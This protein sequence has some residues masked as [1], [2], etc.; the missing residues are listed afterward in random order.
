MFRFCT[1]LTRHRFV[2]LG[3]M[4]TAFVTLL[5]LFVLSLKPSD[6][7]QRTEHTSSS[8]WDKLLFQEDEGDDDGG[9]IG[10][11][12]NS[13]AY[14]Q[15]AKLEDLQPRQAFCPPLSSNLSIAAKYG[16]TP[17]LIRRSVLHASS[18]QALAR[19][20]QRAKSMSDSWRS[21]QKAAFE[22]QAFRVMVIGG[23]GER[24]FGYIY[25]SFG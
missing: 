8:I 19:I 5:C 24:C 18:G 17:S 4:L 14:L 15:D 1:R 7:V 12:D 22:G 13:E 25:A 3:V 21:T 20:L 23:S 2:V 11:D 6:H 10:L 16:E 9:L